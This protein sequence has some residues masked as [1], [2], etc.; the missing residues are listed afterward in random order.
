[1]AKG[2]CWGSSAPQC[3]GATCVTA[4]KHETK[5]NFAASLQAGKRRSHLSRK[6]KK[7]QL[8]HAVCFYKELDRIWKKFWRVCNSGFISKTS[9]CI[10]SAATICILYLKWL[11]NNNSLIN[12]LNA[13][14]FTVI[15]ESF[16]ECGLLI[17]DLRWQSVVPP[18]Y[19]IH[20]DCFHCHA[21]DSALPP[22][23]K[24]WL[25][26]PHWCHR[27]DEL[28]KSFSSWTWDDTSGGWQC[29]SGNL[30]KG[31]PINQYINLKNQL[32]TYHL[33]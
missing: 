3:A 8:A 31:H 32:N 24:K 29:L 14:K 27:E 25:S 17:L 5:I 28:L 30:V 15:S 1:M 20:H 18:Q 2:Q 23:L 10:V 33:P 9:C 12:L 11:A 19:V 4:I 13:V 16:S 22:C 6:K 21:R 7:T 26:F